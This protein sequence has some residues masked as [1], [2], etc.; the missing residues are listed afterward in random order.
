LSE[1]EYIIGIDLGTTHC[2]LAYV[3][4]LA[5]EDQQPEIQVFPVPQVVGAGEVRTQPLL[6]SFLFMPGPHDVPP[7]ALSLPWNAET[8]F[9]VGEFARQRGV[10]LPN[11]LVS[12]AKSWLCHSGV[13]R[14]ASILPWDSPAD[15]RKVSPVKATALYL[16]HSARCVEFFDSRGKGW[17]PF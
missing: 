17:G 12:S 1:P 3:N 13:N 14:T 2:A 16:E 5:P 4:A 11:R 7:D 9:A 6:P 15:G 10:E 8:N